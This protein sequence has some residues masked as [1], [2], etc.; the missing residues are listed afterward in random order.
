MNPARLTGPPMRL[1]LSG[2]P[3][4]MVGGVRM[5]VCGITPYAVTH[6]G[7]AA[8]YVWADA[9]E[10]VLRWHGHTVTVARNVTDVDDVLFAEARRR[11]ESHVMLATLQRA[12]FEATMA[13]LQVRQPD[14]APT[15]AQHIGHVVQLAN[16][17]LDQ[18]AAYERN[19]T[20]YART[21]HS[22]ALA[23]IDRGTAL[24]LAEE[25]HDRPDDPDKDD[26]LDVTVWQ[27]SGPDD[28]V[29]WPSPWGEGR[30]GWHAECAAMVLS[31]FGSG[32]DIHAGGGDLAF[33]HHACE[34]ALAEGATGVT[35]FAR[36]WMRAGTVSVNGAKMAKSTGNLV[37][38][39][40][41][42]RSYS[43]GA[44]RLMLLN[45][46]WAQPWEYSPGLLDTAEATLEQLYA[47][48]A[49][50]GNAPGAAAVPAALLDDVDVP[51][52]V[53]VAL[54]DGGQAARTLIEILALT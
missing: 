32:V 42:L 52:A 18:H 8:T 3:V 2:K 5:Y 34:T 46:P 37:L 47:A 23:G 41:L 54:E 1:H 45:R 35:P 17:L 12:A 50:P 13:T 25:F 29:A 26:P 53:A 7:H 40:D 39:E 11:G 6:L 48:A 20:V 14:H 38:V 9:L 49:S 21:A 28:D 31:L 36:A 10:R 16:A 51:R 44:I 43:P 27:A 24:R 19:G 15:A 22:A 4:P 33:P 30:P